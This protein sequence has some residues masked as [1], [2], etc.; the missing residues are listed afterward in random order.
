M[1]AQMMAEISLICLPPAGLQE[2]MPH[3]MN[4]KSVVLLDVSVV[5]HLVAIP[6][7]GLAAIYYIGLFVRMVFP[8]NSEIRQLTL[9]SLMEDRPLQSLNMIKIS[10]LNG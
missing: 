3:M 2:T 5:M 10:I 1:S 4:Q 9:I 7:S 8:V 6:I